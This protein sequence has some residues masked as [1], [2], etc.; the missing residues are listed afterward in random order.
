[1]SR[2]EGSF[3]YF[4]SLDMVLVALSNRFTIL[5]LSPPEINVLEDKSTPSKDEYLFIYLFE[6]IKF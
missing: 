1:M 4:G 5:A 2:Y 3:L 6:I